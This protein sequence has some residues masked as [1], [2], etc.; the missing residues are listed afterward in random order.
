MRIWKY[1]TIQTW[2]YTNVHVEKYRWE[3]SIRECKE[4]KYIYENYKS[5]KL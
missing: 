1:K 3:K 5:Y 4:N 2:Q